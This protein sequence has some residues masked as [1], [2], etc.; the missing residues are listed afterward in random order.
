ML[1]AGKRKKRVRRGKDK[2][3]WYLF[4]HMLYTAKNYELLK[5]GLNNVVLAAL[6]NVVNNIV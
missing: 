1:R 2:G 3:V 4:K 6:F 5:T